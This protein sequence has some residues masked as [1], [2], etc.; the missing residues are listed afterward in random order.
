MGILAVA[1][2]ASVRARDEDEAVGIPGSAD[3]N[4]A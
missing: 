1:F 4:P 2:V 3:T